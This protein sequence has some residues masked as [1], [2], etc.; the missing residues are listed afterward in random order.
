MLS[1]SEQSLTDTSV[2]SGV[3]SKAEMSPLHAEDAQGST[4]GLDSKHMNEDEPPLETVISS[5]TA[6]LSQ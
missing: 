1:G 3:A 5:D 6:P 2:S 4:S